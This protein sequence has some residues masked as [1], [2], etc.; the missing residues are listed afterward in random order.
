MKNKL[1]L[2]TFFVVVGGGLSALD[3]PGDRAS[4]LVPEAYVPRNSDFDLGDEDEDRGRKGRL[5]VVRGKGEAA[6]EIGKMQKRSLGAGY[7]PAPAFDAEMKQQLDDLRASAPDDFTDTR[8]AIAGNKPDESDNK[9]TSGESYDSLKES[10]DSDAENDPYEDAAER[11]ERVASHRAGGKLK[12]HDKGTGVYGDSRGERRSGD[13]YPEVLASRELRNAAQKAKAEARGLQAIKQAESPILRTQNG[14]KERQVRQG[15]H[16]SSANVIKGIMP[17]VLQLPVKPPLTEL[18]QAKKEA[19]KRTLNGVKESE[20][21]AAV[22]AD[23]EA[24][25]RIS[26]AVHQKDTSDG[27]GWVQGPAQRPSV[28]GAIYTKLKQGKGARAAV[29]TLT[30]SVSTVGQASTT[31]A[32]TTTQNTLEAPKDENPAQTGKPAGETNEWSAG[33]LTGAGAAGLGMA[34]LL[35]AKEITNPIARERFTNAA[36]KLV[37]GPQRT[38]MT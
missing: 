15:W 11:A 36:R 35:V 6:Y 9:S 10:Y 38:K 1:I 13:I 31:Q 16:E 19:R 20:L 21:D 32:A 4:L 34:F 17:E 5:F 33:K 18:E 3:A 2:L 30:D 37:S 12:R 23:V 7:E 8:N 22:R 26:T 28:Q 27:R 24:R 29:G 14:G 25:L